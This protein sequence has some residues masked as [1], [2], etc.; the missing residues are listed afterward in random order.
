[1]VKALE[2]CE[3]NVRLKLAGEFSP[4]SLR[5]E[6]IQY[7]GWGRVDELGFLDR[8]AMKKVYS[9]SI[10]GL[11]TLLPVVN[12]LDGLPV[13]MFEYMSAG[14]SLIASNFPLWEAIIEENKCGICV[15]PTKPEEIAK[16]IDYLENNKE[17]AYSMGQN[18]KKA[19]KEKYNWNIEEK[20]LLEVYSE[21]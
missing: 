17:I 7:K 10:V 3:N 16:A 14:L 11:V 8:E 15:D 1:M 12:Y 6:V 4:P 9:E 18:G 20:K 5:E 21:L 19:V 13:K 2:Y